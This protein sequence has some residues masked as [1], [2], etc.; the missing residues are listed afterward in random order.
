MSN[1]KSL[2]ELYRKITGVSIYTPKQ[3]N[4]TVQSWQE[5]RIKECAFK[6]SS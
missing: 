2:F 3:S 4:G 5:S 6:E 1:Q